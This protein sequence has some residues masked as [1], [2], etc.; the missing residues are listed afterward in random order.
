MAKINTS[1][2]IQKKIEDAKLLSNFLIE[3]LQRHSFISELETSNFNL[4]NFIFN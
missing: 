4:M 1:L 3:V 2:E